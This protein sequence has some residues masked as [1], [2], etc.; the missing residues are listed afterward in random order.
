[1][2]SL[3]KDIAN[4]LFP[5]YCVCCGERLSKQEKHICV[6]CIANLPRTNSHICSGLPP[7]QLFWGKLPIERVVCYFFHEG[8]NTK[9]IIWSLKY[10][11]QPDIGRYVAHIYAKEIMEHGIFNSIDYIIPVPLSQRKRISRGYNQCDYIAK[12]I[13][14][15]TGIPIL[16]NVVKRI[17]H[18]DSQTNFDATQRQEN[19]KGIFSI[20]HPELIRGK[21]ILMVDDVLTTG[22][23]LCSLGQVICQ[24]G[25]VKISVLTLALAGTLKG[26]PFKANITCS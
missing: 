5:Q 22:A 24:A 15:V 23:T 14:E 2:I 25:N 11:N 20:V 17:K 16:T 9:Q 8:T 26:I 21:H 3:L 10:N 13:S 6:S 19:V 12:G 1:M 18:N 4:F 7:E